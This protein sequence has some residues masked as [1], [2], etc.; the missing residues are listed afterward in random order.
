MESMSQ[1]AALVYGMR[2]RH[3]AGNSQLVDGMIH[4]GLW[5]RFP[6]PTWVT[7]RYTPRRAGVSRADHG[8]VRGWRATRS[9][10]RNGRQCRFKAEI[11]PVEIPG[12][13]GADRGREDEVRAGDLARRAG[14]AQAV[15]REDG[16][17]TP[18]RARVERRRERVGVTS[19]AF[20]KSA[21]SSSRWPASPRTPAPAVSPRSVLRPIVAVHNLMKKANTT[22]AITI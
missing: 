5:D 6:T 20:A 21:R 19:L 7:S 22:T 10:G 15:L 9:G 11:V 14:R 13:K 3:Q 4:D 8:R 1:R 17:V 2:G 16:T 12:K 18:E